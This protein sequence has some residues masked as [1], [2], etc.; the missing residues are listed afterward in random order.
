MGNSGE[1][2]RRRG[3]GI[4]SV[5]PIYLPFIKAAP[6]VRVVAGIGF[7]VRNRQ[8]GSSNSVSQTLFAKQLSVADTN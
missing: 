5:P 8:T 7:C 4:L 6:R 2:A 1:R 3:G